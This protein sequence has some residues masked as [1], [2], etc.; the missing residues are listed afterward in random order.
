MEVKERVIKTILRK[1]DITGYG[2]ST[3]DPVCVYNIYAQ[4]GTESTP[5]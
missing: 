3:S 5:R 4:K 2:G 1:V